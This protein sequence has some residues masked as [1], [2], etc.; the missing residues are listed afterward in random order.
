ML[1]RALLVWIV[2]TGVARGETFR[3]VAIDGEKLDQAWGKLFAQYEEPAGAVVHADISELGLKVGDL[4]RTINGAFPLGPAAMAADRLAV[5]YF[6]VV[7]GKQ[8]FVLRVAIKPASHE[9]RTSRDSYA[10]QLEYLG[11]PTGLVQLTT[12]GI[13]SGVALATA[14]W[15]DLGYDGD[16]IRAIDRKPT[17]TIKAALEALARAKDHDKVVVQLERADQAFVVTIVLGS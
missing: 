7:R 12:R 10:K 5:V 11:G 9:L 1:T 6:D 8:A 4:V 14:S 16:V 15:S 2:V 17:T 3:S 13:P